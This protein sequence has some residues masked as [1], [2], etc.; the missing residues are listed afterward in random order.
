MVWAVLGSG[1]QPV[2]FRHGAWYWSHKACAGLEFRDV[3]HGQEKQLCV[4]SS[5]GRSEECSCGVRVHW[6]L[7]RAF[8]F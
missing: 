6:V 5:W 2:C 1:D 4:G 7:H 8:R 3:L